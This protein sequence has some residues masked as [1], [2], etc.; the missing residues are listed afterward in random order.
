[1]REKFQEVLELQSLHSSENTPPMVRRGQLIRNEIPQEL[2]TWPAAQ[3][4]AALPFRGRLAIRG[5]DGTGLK[6]FVP[7]VRIHSPELSPSPQAG[8]YVVF[9]FHA[10]GKGVSLCVMHG[11]TRWDGADF[12]P[13][14]ADE[15]ASLMNWGRGIVGGLAAKF[16]MVPG[17][18][19]GFEERLSRAYERTTA[20]SKT[21]SIDA[22]PTD[23]ELIRD[24]SAAVN[25]LGELYRALELGRA[26]TSTPPEI[27]AAVEA[28]SQVSRPNGPTRKAGQGFGLTAA[29]RAVV[30]DHAMAMA[31]AW[32]SDH[33]YADIRDV[34]KTSSC[35]FIAI[36]DGEEFHVEVKG[37]TSAF[38]SILI[39]ASE[40]DLHRSRHPNNVLVVVYDIDLA[41][42]R[43]K[44][45][46]GTIKAFEA[47]DVGQATLR[48][49]SF[50]CFLDAGPAPSN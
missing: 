46:G 23:D 16:G 25:L 9:L 1:M 11:S 44:A 35:D 20:F 10:D 33:G 40:V 37:T 27:T 22:L 14:S 31:H 3:T 48:P 15:A 19:L 29:E 47:W 39:T 18:D 41:P 32:L 24:T 50:Q 13:R 30:E 17:V 8:W 43:M 6:T 26:P 34:H 5:K 4:D 49:L 36:K 2:R 38:G 42:M 21:Y 12:K 45:H 28:T 7:W